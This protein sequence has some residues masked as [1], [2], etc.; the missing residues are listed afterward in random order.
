MAGKRVTLKEIAVAAGVSTT[1]V[2]KYLNQRNGGEMSAST[3]TR[4]DEAISRLGYRP[5]K[6][7]QAL[8]NGHTKTLGMVLTNLD[9]PH[10]GALAQD[11][12]LATEELGY[13][14]LLGM[15]DYRVH[16]H[17]TDGE[18]IQNL[19]DHQVEGL[20]LTSRLVDSELI[21]DLHRRH[22]PIV[23]SN[24]FE[25][26]F[27][28]VSFDVR[29][30]CYEAL[31]HLKSLGAKHIALLD[32][33]YSP[34]VAIPD[35]STRV[36]WIRK[37]TARAENIHDIIQEMSANGCDAFLLG[38]GMIAEAFLN[39]IH[40]HFP[41]YHPLVITCTD[42]APRIPICRE[43]VGI[44]QRDYRQQIRLVFEELVRQVESQTETPPR[45]IVLT[46]IFT[47]LTFQPKEYSHE[48]KY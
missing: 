22:F 2:S 8:R 30:C 15:T 33:L 7:A 41:S 29:Q 3:K 39:H 48:K 40:D 12:F 18:R 16:K 44:I 1:L 43:L 27:S 24:D 42:A 28:C 23:L 9:N 11:A 6:L 37:V 32:T 14:L 35:I 19:L 34:L 13:E 5:S 4:V 45:K 26:K 17:G 46:P 25:G 38:G 31:A 36:E 10:F 20:F 21:R 47:P